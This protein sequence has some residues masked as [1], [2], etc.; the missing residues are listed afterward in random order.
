[1][2]SAIPA[3]SAETLGVYFGSCF[4]SLQVKHNGTLIPC[5]DICISWCY[6]LLCY[7]P[8]PNT[9][10]NYTY[11]SQCL[12]FLQCFIRAPFAIACS[13]ILL[14]VACKMYHQQ[15]SAL[16]RIFGIKEDCPTH[17]LDYKNNTF[18]FKRVTCFDPIGSSSPLQKYVTLRII[19]FIIPWPE[20]SL[21]SNY[22][23]IACIIAA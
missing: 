22:S 9:S 10:S 18:F 11:H 4:S 12:S 2:H 3:I 19:T 21:E 20:I 1:M 6:P 7:C 14:W 5:S 15:I 13:C 8:C 23:F 17:L 16:S